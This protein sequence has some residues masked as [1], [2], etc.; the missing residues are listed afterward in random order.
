MT[1]RY[2]RLLERQKDLQGKVSAKI[3][4][5]I[6]NVQQV[7]G[8]LISQERNLIPCNYDNNTFQETNEKEE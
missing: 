4:S 3:S 8:V 2:E 5:D 7:L 1:L 6:Y